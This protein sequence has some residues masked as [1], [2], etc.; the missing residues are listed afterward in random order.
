[1][2]FAF[3]PLTGQFDYFVSDFPAP[4]FSSSTPALIS[5]DTD[6]DLTINGSYF[7]EDMTTSDVSSSAFSAVNS[8][9]FVSDNEITVNVDVTG[10]AGDYDLTLN[11]GTEATF[12]DALTVSTLLFLDIYTDAKAGYGLRNLRVANTK[13]IRIRRDSDN[14]EQEI[15]FDSDGLVDTAAA[16]TFCGAAN[17]YVKTLYDH[18][19]NLTPYDWTV[20]NTSYQ[21][22][23][24]SSGT[25]ITNDDGEPSIE[26]IGN[27]N[28][29]A[30]LDL[31]STSNMEIYFTMQTADTTQILLGAHNAS[32]RYAFVMESGSALTPHS[33]A[34][35]PTYQ[36]NGNAISSP[37]RD[38]LATEFATDTPLLASIRGLSTQP[39]IWQ[40][41]Y[42]GDY[43]SATY[44]VDAKINC[45]IAFDTD[46][47]SNHTGIVN[48]LINLFNITV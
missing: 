1:M 15:G 17:G 20:T 10:T 16:E 40:S 6:V 35:S 26:C 30:Q 22:Q 27:R 48:N 24:V 21:A 19:D 34:G 18:Q 39:N 3:N 4:Y 37:D 45:F 36:K 5:N 47:T 41:I 12:T 43:P 28:L 32:S 9:T 7:T 42:W 31:E 8:V 33:N 14:A 23:V 38:D 25:F 2:G 29:G 44:F 46:Q 11:N 13:C